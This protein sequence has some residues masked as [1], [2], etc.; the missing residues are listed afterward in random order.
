MPVGDG[1]LVVLN[2]Y[3]RPQNMSRIIDA[4]K[5]QTAKPARL[6][7]V[8]NTQF[9]DYVCGEQYP[10]DIL[11]GSDDVWKWQDNCGCFAHL[12]PALVLTGYKYILLADDDVVPGLRAIEHLL[13]TA[14]FLDDAFATLGQE[15]R[16][17]LLDQPPG[18]RYSGRSCPVRSTTES[19]KTHITC[20]AHLV[21]ADLVHG[22]LQLRTALIN[23]FGDEAVQLCK[24]HD[25][26]LLSLG[27]QC[28]SPYPSYVIPRTR[29]AADELIAE[30]P[31]CSDSTSVYKRPTHFAERARM[32][33]MCLEVGWR[34]CP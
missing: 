20:Q 29:D 10:R 33:D 26:F 30:R 15:G 17:F 2:N 12:A 18:K 5:G 6:V 16:L 1:V 21:R 13:R 24:V 14:K 19:V 4:W 31:G 28:I 8:D 27:T 32:V 23:R 22:V 34:P 7:V 9:G 3:A 11:H 25:D